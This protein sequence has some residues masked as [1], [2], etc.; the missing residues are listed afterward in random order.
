MLLWTYSYVVCMWVILQYVLL[1][2]YCLIDICCMSFAFNYVLINCFM[3]LLIYLCSF[4]FFECFA[5]Y[6]ACSVFLYCFVIC[7]STCKYLFSTY[8]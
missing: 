5:F 3:F 2:S 8:V 4:Y 1:L 6:V 7:F